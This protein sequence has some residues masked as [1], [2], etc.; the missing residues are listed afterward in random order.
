MDVSKIDNIENIICTGT[1]AYEIAIRFKYEYYKNISVEPLTE[2][3]VKKLLTNNNTTK[4][5][6]SNYTGLFELRKK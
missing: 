1:R 2:D 4:Y 3:A 5:A 6:I